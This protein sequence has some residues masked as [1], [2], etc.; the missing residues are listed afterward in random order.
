MSVSL[1]HRLNLCFKSVYINRFTESLNRNKKIKFRPWRIIFWQK[2]SENLK[3]SRTNSAVGKT[4]ET[5]KAYSGNFEFFSLIH[6]S[7]CHV[8]R[9]SST[10]FRDITDLHTIAYTCLLSCLPHFPLRFLI[11]K[12]NFFSPFF[13]L[14]LDVEWFNVLAV[15]SVPCA[16]RQEKCGAVF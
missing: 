2:K 13:S 8:P 16:D 12:T 15:V 6:F 3:F 4:V 7:F 14:T 11:H 10:S 1:L 9:H 5:R